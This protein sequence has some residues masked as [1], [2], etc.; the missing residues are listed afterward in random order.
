M[1]TSKVIPAEIIEN[2]ILLIRG[3]KVLLD[4]D[5]ALLYGVTTMA[6][7]QAVSRNI[8]RF[9]SDFM[10]QLTTEELKT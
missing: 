9:P 8:T 5:L 1:P 2:K 4:K 3:Q 10:F 6:L 7:N